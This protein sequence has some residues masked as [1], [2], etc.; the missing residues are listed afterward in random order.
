MD[1]SFVNTHLDRTLVEA[2]IPELPGHYRGKVR[3]SY[4]LGNGRRL[5]IASDRLSAFDRILCAVPFKGQV[6]TE[7]ARFWFDLTAD[8]C[9]NHM[10]DCPD[11]NAMLCRDL[12]MVP[13]EMVVRGYLA[14]TTNTSILTF[15]RSGRRTMYGVTLPDGMQAYDALAEPMITPTSKASANGHDE[16][17]SGQEIVTSGLVDAARWD[18]MCAVS[19]ALFARGQAVAKSRGLILADTKYEFG[20]DDQGT[21]VLADEIHTPDSSRF[22]KAAGFTDRIRAGA[23][24]ESFDKDVIRSWVAARCDPYA[25]QLP[26]IP[27]ALVADTALVYV[28]ALEQITGTPFTPDLTEADPLTRI[29]K[30]LVSAAV[31]G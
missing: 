30:R 9:P 26:P 15:Y 4:D 13:V 12:Q 16:P 22:W 8:I 7:T 27:P 19:L 2:T 20:I 6:L 18:E 17:L 1:R 25:E 31:G 5:M 3:D 10:L 24:P 23:P 28:D 14:G 11:P 21:L 29:R